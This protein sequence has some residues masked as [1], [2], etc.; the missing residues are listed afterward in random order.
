VTRLGPERTGDGGDSPA[1]TRKREGYTGPTNLRPPRDSGGFEIRV[2][3]AEL[4]T[5]SHFSFLDGASSPEALV[6]QAV[7]AGLD[8]ITLTD[9]DGMYGVVRFAEAARELG[10]RVGYGAELSLGLTGAQNGSADPEGTHLLVLARGLEGYR[11]LCRVISNA[12]LRGEEKG[13]PVYDHDEI[14][15]ELRGHSVVLTGC[16]KGAVRQALTRFGPAAAAAELRGLADRF[17]RH[18]YQ[19]G[20]LD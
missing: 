4:H 9:H 16:R 10:M 11:R 19:G 13:Q 15:E 5:H 18:H 8:A 14:V 6:E 7:R 1:W 12:Q 17:G 2:P 3:Y 20:Q